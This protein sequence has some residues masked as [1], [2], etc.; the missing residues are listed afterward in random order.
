MKKVIALAVVLLTATALIAHPHFQKTTSAKISEELELSLSFFTVPANM[1][2]VAKIGVG[3]FASPGLPKF[4]ASSA[5]MAGSANIPAGTYTVG[6]VKKS[7][8]DWQMVL[9][10]GELA[11]GDS[12]DMAK[13]IE[14]ES[15]FRMSKEPVAHLVVDIFPGD[16]EFEGKA[17]IL[18]GFGSMWVQGLVG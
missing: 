14:L 11:F 10:P 2:H 5:V 3:E 12:P 6:V 4:K 7:D 17:V 16:G 15:S 1:E 9:S 18:L 13:L 8:S